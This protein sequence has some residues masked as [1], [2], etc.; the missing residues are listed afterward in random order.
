MALKYLDVESEEELLE[1]ELRSKGAGAGWGAY[2]E[3]KSLVIFFPQVCLVSYFTC[4]M[5]FKSR[6]N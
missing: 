2:F 5:V 1:H 6:S 3:T 4:Q